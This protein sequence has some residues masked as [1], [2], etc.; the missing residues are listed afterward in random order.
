MHTNRRNNFIKIYKGE[1]FI[2]EDKEEIL[3]DILNN[4]MWRLEDKAVELEET[5]KINDKIMEGHN[6]FKKNYYIND[7]DSIKGR[8]VAVENLLL[9]NKEITN[10][11]QKS[12][13]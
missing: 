13:K 3:S 2:T 4:N 12:I 10:N 6:K 9:D 7:K 1:S 11:T 5:R 8:L